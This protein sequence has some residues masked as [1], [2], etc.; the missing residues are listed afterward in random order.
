MEER[1][2]PTLPKSLYM[3]AQGALGNPATLPFSRIEAEEGSGSVCLRDRELA[4]P[5]LNS[6]VRQPQSLS[7]FMQG[8]LSGTN[9][10]SFGGL[11]RSHTSRGEP[12]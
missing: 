1:L 4:V 5:L 11:T 3:L 8:F 6:D 7:C 2:S 10:F 9:Q 12:Q